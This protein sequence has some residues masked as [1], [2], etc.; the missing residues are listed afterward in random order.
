MPSDGP[1]HG[2]R[3]LELGNGAGAM[4]GRALAGLGASVSRIALAAGGPVRAGEGPSLSP[5]RDAWY[6]LDKDIVTIDAA[7]AAM[8]LQTAL[9]DADVLIDGLPPDRL[10]ALGLDPRDLR[11]RFPRL[12]VL[13]ITDYGQDGPYRDWAGS[14]L[15]NFALGGSLFRAGQPVEPP[16]P[17][18]AELADTIGGVT[19]ALAVAAALAA[20]GDTGEGDWIDCSIAESCVATSD[21][22]I[23]GRSISGRT[24]ERNGSGPLYPVY[25]VTDGFVRVINLSPKQ[26]AAFKAWLGH[27]PELAGPEWNAALFRVANADVLDLVFARETAGR[28]RE[29]LFHSGQRAGVSVVPVY[30]PEDIAGDAHFAAR[31][32]LATVPH[33]TL[34][35][36]TVPR[37]MVRFGTTVPEGPRPPRI[38][39]A[40]PSPP[41]AVVGAPIDFSALRVVELGAGGVAP[42]AARFLALLGADVIKVESPTAPDFLRALA[43]PG[44]FEMSAAWASSNR[45]KRSIVLDLKTERDRDTL[46][47]LIAAADV[48]LENNSGDVCDRLG[49][50]YDVAA[51]RN[52][53]LIYGRSQ[54]FGCWGEAASY[55]GFG[56]SNHAVSGLTHLWTAP[57]NPR[58]EGTSL[59]HPDHLSGKA[60]ALATI[61]ALIDRQRT[62]KGHLID[63]SQGEFAMWTIGECFVEASLTGAGV[64]RGQEHPEFV[65]H[66]VFPTSLPDE[67]VAVAVETDDHWRR[68]HSVVDDN[69]WARDE[70]LA[71]AEGR[72]AAR[73]AITEALKDWTRMETRATVVAA[74]QAAGVPAMPVLSPVEQLA[75]PHL[76]ARDAFD[77]VHH[78]LLGW[79]RYEGLP[80]RF[81]RLDVRPSRRAPLMGE[82]TSEVIAEWLGQPV[83]SASGP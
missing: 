82:H 19:G 1:L 14:A 28:T 18:P 51:A 50:G 26:W 54:V 57:G 74:L 21:W 34:G 16:A 17:P 79:G 37:A 35:A 5:A 42:E 33:D 58:P 15:T 70:S 76:T 75:D 47:N 31:H 49:I 52:P 48:F 68:L 45:N 39:P 56:P 24:T 72:R 3:V 60:L 2:F 30:A 20:R 61:A 11:R 81:E 63:L 83:M 38:M 13:S 23:P 59:V 66:G 32:A 9:A 53:R 44:R 4:A 46:L 80:V 67:W 62:G 65:P 22:A 40:L 69:C 77:L 25:R 78:P 36:L 73:V 10:P 29:E 12:V 71:T 6:A 55:S 8:V 43:G 64:R 7:R 41:P 27:P